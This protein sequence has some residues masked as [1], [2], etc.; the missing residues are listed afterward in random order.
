MTLRLRINEGLRDRD[1]ALALLLE[2]L[3]GIDEHSFAS[4]RMVAFS[5]ENAPWALYYCEIVIGP[6][7][8][9][10]PRLELDRVVVLSESIGILDLIARFHEAR[11]TGVFRCGGIETDVSKIFAYWTFDRYASGG[12]YSRWPCVVAGGRQDAG[13]ARVGPFTAVT[14][15]GRLYFERC[16]EIVGYVTTFPVFHGVADGRT[17]TMYVVIE[18]HRARITSIDRQGDRLSIRADGHDIERCHLVGRIIDESGVVSHFDRPRAFRDAASDSD[19]SC[20]SWSGDR[21]RRSRA[22]RHEERL[23][24]PAVRHRSR[25]RPAA[26]AGAR[27]RRCAPLARWRVRIV[28]IQAMGGTHARGMRSSKRSR[29]PRSR[30]QTVTA[31]RSS[32]APKT[33]GFRLASMAR[34]WGPFLREVIEESAAATDDPSDP[35][36]RHRDAVDAF[37]RKLRDALQ[38]IVEP[39]LELDVKVVTL[40]GGPVLVL[41]VR[42]GLMPPYMIAESREVCVRRN[43]TNRRP[44]REELRLLHLPRV[45]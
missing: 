8:S 2:T 22:A 43:A 18:D 4:I 42:P 36:E 31:V 35:S 14:E 10:G 37:G 1:N 21:E 29:E 32:S 16:S 9:S 34:S 25:P 44:T 11:E 26:R 3:Q 19:G 27:R 39:S 45:T 7:A 24:Y 12:R 41:G 38:Q 13:D 20:R 5:S 33:T 28:R 15:D 6:E 30:W 17:W 40:E 23:C